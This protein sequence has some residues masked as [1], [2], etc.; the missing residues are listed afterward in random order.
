[1]FIVWAQTPVG[2]NAV[3]VVI[4]HVL[5]W[6]PNGDQCNGVAFVWSCTDVLFV[7]D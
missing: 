7:V 1:M 4:L 6:T 3:D 2:V 5:G